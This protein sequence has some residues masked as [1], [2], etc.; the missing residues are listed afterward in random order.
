MA[1]TYI[2]NLRN[3]E[4]IASHTIIAHHF[5]LRLRGLIGRKTLTKQEA[6]WISPCQQ[7]HT[8]WM[9]YALLIVYLDKSLKVVHI[10]HHLKPWRFSPLVKNAHSLI[11]LNAA[12]RYDIEV[13][14]YLAIN[15]EQV[16]K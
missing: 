3:N 16:G 9:G 12:Y 11:E 13:G 14:D 8:H 6:I 1:I 4:L 5:L 7:V 2:T 15:A 10:V